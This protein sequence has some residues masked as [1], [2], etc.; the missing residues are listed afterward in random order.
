MAALGT[1]HE[2]MLQYSWPACRNVLLMMSS[3]AVDQRATFKRWRPCCSCIICNIIQI[4]HQDCKAA[5]WAY[6]LASSCTIINLTSLSEHLE[7]TIYLSIGAPHVSRLP[8]EHDR[9]NRCNE[10]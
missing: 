4:L 10:Y 7:S 5:Q 8:G 6:V 1:D 3:Y 9:M 2:L